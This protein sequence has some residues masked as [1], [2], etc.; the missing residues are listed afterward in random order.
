MSINGNIGKLEETLKVLADVDQRLALTLKR[1]NN[2][3]MG[4][5][6]KG[7]PANVTPDDLTFKFDQHLAHFMSLN[8]SIVSTIEALDTALGVDTGAVDRPKGYNR[9]LSASQLAEQREKEAA[10]KHGARHGRAPADRAFNVTAQRQQFSDHVTGDAA[11]KRDAERA[12]DEDIGGA[13]DE[14]G[15]DDHTYEEG[16]LQR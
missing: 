5:V 7:N 15:I 2:T 10:A 8:E 14:I 11:M 3:E 9:K 6:S 4:L 1:I 12:F 16:V 13:M